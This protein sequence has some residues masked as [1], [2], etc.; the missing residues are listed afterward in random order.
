MAR[1]TWCSRSE[2]AHPCM[3]CRESALRIS[4]SSVPWGR[5]SDMVEA[6]RVEMSEG[7]PSDFYRTEAIVALVEVQG[8]SRLPGTGRD[9]SGT[10]RPPRSGSDPDLP[11][12][13]HRVISTLRCTTLP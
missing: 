5:S 1:E 13:S 9:P 11:S 10:G 7:L 6:V 4:R 12:S 8:E 3:G 2:I